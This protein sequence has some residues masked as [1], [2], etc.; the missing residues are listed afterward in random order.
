MGTSEISIRTEIQPGDIER[1]IEQHRILYEEEFGFNSDFSDYVATTL[2]GNIERIW[3][4]EQNGEFAGCIGIV[5]V[6]KKNVQLRW[7]LVEPSARGNGLG[8]KLMYELLEYCNNK[9]YDL[10]FLWTVNKLPA[11]RKLYELFAF[12]LVEENPESILW[13]QL[14]KEQR[15]DLSLNANR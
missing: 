14:L 12:Q 9:S 15:W 7:L 2:A 3:I 4:A 10:I 5:E 11:A 6:E 8:Q 13:G 1:I